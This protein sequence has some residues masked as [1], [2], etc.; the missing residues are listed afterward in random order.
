MTRQVLRGPFLPL[1]A[2]GALTAVTALVG[3]GAAAAHPHHAAGFDRSTSCP[4]SPA[5]LA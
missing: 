3:A 5:W 1:L 2:V 4:I